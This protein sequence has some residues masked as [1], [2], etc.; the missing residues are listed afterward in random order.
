[1]NGTFIKNTLVSL[2]N[3][4]PN[5]TGSVDYVSL[6]GNQISTY[7]LP[8]W[9][10]VNPETGHEEI[11]EVEKDDYRNPNSAYRFT[12]RKIRPERLGQ[13]DSN[14]V[15]MAD[16][17]L[18][19]KFYGGFTNRFILYK[20]LE[21]SFFFTFSLGNYLLDQGERRQ[22]YFT[23]SNNLREGAINAW[24][25]P[26]QVTD[27]PKLYYANAQ[28]LTGAT[29]TLGS[30]FWYTNDPMRFRNSSRFLHD[31]SYVRLRTVTISYSFSE[32]LCKRIKLQSMRI[33]ASAQNLMT[34]TK[35]PGWDPEVVG[36]LGSNSERNLQIGT[37]DLD[38]PQLKSYTMGI[39]ITF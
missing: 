32:I 7:Y 24:S 31:G 21:I 38:F 25:K 36:N 27:Q 23:G 3:V 35:F 34:F 28:N 26:G 10:G 18:M 39:N 17:P 19:P 9:A 37:T 29:D 8:K 30:S 16:K 5:A 6:V 15:A 22:S 33:F 11:Y 12:G 1:L 14:R 4:P 2:G 13:I 20:N